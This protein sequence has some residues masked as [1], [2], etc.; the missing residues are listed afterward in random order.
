MPCPASVGELSLCLFAS[1]FVLVWFGLV[2]PG[3]VW[4]GLVWSGL[5]WSGLVWS[6]LVWLLSLGGLLFSEGK[7]S[8]SGSKGEGNWKE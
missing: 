4:F 3:L 2:W 7:W 8:G 1:C 5:V 6:G